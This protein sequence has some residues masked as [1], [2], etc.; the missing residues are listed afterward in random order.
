MLLDMRLCT[1]SFEADFAVHAVFCQGSV[2]LA[3]HHR[4]Q[5]TARWDHRQPEDAR[6]GGASAQP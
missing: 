5:R 1:D 6:M 2:C 4:F 3:G